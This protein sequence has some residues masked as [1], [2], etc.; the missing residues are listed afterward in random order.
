M[1]NNAAINSYTLQNANGMQLTVLN[2]GAIIQKLIVPDKNEDPVNV[3]IGYP[4]KEDYRT[5]PLRLGA[6][7]GRYA[8]RISGGAFSLNDKTYELHTEESVHLH[9]GFKGFDQQFWVVDEFVSD[10]NSPHIKLSYVSKDMEE[11][12]PGNLK[13]EVTYELTNSNALKISY[14]AIADAS[15]IINLTNHSYFNLGGTE[16]IKTHELYIDADTYLETDDDLIP[17]GKFL[18]I[19]GSAYDFNTKKEIGA[20]IMDHV[21]VLNQK[22]QKGITLMSKDSGIEMHI[23]T[24]QPGCV[25]F[26]PTTFGGICFETQNFPDAP[27]K[28]DFPSAILNPGE[29]YKHNTVLSFKKKK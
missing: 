12:Y 28:P 23:K 10:G 22:S 26:T 3:V 4:N 21:F 29:T 24:N 20:V 17:T 25:V 27:N 1:M 18:K 9:G 19:K 13:A 2:Y 5:N 15:T 6:C 7:I 16:S 14:S 11:G 8:G